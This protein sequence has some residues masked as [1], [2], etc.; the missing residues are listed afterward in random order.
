MKILYLCSDSGIPVLG[1]KGAS[2]HVRELVGAFA[3]A[4]HQVVLAAPV[5]S[6]SPW[7]KP[8]EVEANLLHVRL[9]AS[10]QT[11]SQHVRNFTQQL[12]L[13]SSLPGELRRI[14]HNQELEAELIARLDKDSPDF[15]YERAAL[16]GTAGAV[17]AKA[18]NVPLVVELNA[19]LA[20]EQTAYRGNGLGDLGAQAERWALGQADAVLAVSAPLRDHVLD[21]GIDPSK[22]HVIPNGV[23]TD[24]FYPAPPDA[25][26]RARL[27]LGEGPVLGF[28]GG[29][30]PWHG[31]ESLPEIL[32]RV[33]TNH[34]GARLVIVGD[35]PL[36]EGLTRGLIERGLREQAVFT[37]ALPH[38]EVPAVIR[39]FD[40][41][42]APYPAFDH[43]FYFS[44]LKLFEY[45]ACGV[46]VVA[47]NCGQIADVIRDGE[48]GLLHAP[49]ELD[50]LV[51]ACDR[52]LD[53]AKLRF[54]LGQSA[55]A[56]VRGSYTWT[57]NARRVTELAA[58]LIC[59][60]KS[61]GG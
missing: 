60:R 56:H 42:L 12:G 9:A 46:P 13:D 53:N 3:R 39:Q 58:S 27:G 22:V 19:P 28:V 37:G 4:G 49:G 5:L 40:I 15:I 2:I 16:Y 20:V 17:V 33:S 18:L 11:A 25:A 26:L 29:L 59:R 23:D 24:L 35:G 34:P 1:R 57:H 30:R 7:E 54:A 51:A 31:I 36:R 48:T 10:A 44:P 6:K 32:A 61:G 21:L 50:A 47:A 38:D 43:A 8:A 55:A 52:L 14:L 41:A 45:M